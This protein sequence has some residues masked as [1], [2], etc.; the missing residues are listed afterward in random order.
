MIKP[1][2]IAA[3]LAF[4]AA[5]SAQELP[6]IEK[7]QPVD[8]PR[9]A[10]ISFTE[11]HFPETRDAIA[12]FLNGKDSDHPCFLSTDDKLF[13]F[14]LPKESATVVRTLGLSFLRLRRNEV[15]QREL[16]RWNPGFAAE[17]RHSVPDSARLGSAASYPVAL[18]VG[19]ATR[20]RGRASASQTDRA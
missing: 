18:S 12:V 8:G 10:S 14:C 17:I 11:T 19:E 4:A 1:G 20:G 15:G 7:M 9:G 6:V 5:G 16:P 2:H 13:E 3:A